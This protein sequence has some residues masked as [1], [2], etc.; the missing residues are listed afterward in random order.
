MRS[1]APRSNLIF[2]LVLQILITFAFSGLPSTEARALLGFL[3]GDLVSELSPFTVEVERNQSLCSFNPLLD[4]RTYYCG[5]YGELK[6]PLYDN[7]YKWHKGVL[8]QDV[9]LKTSLVY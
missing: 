5:Y 4:T 9:T 1:S 6:I 3:G 2:S 8:E 7:E